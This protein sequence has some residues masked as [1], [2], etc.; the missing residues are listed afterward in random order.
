MRKKLYQNFDLEGH[1]NQS[2]GNIIDVIC[3]PA[4]WSYKYHMKLHLIPLLLT[5]R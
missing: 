4:V 3:I 2:Q 5:S 1:V